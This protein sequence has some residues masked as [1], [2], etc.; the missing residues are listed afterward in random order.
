MAPSHHAPLRRLSE[1]AETSCMCA[2]PDRLLHSIKN[3]S[4]LSEDLIVVSVGPTGNLETRESGKPLM[5]TQVNEHKLEPDWLRPDF[6]S[7]PLCSICSE[8]QSILQSDQES[9]LQT[10]DSIR[11]SAETCP[12]CAIISNAVPQWQTFVPDNTR[13]VSIAPTKHHRVEEILID[14]FNIEPG[15]FLTGVRLKFPSM[16]YGTRPSIRQGN[17]ALCT[18]HGSSL[19]FLSSTRLTF[20]LDSQ[21]GRSGDV[22]GRVVL[23]PG[24]LSNAKVWLQNC[25][26][27]HKECWPP[28]A[29]F[30]ESYKPRLPT[31]V[32]DV[33]SSKG[34]IVLFVTEGQT[35]DYLSLSHR[36]G[37]SKIPITTTDNLAAHLVSIPWESLTRTFQDAVSVTRELGYRYL[38]IDSLCIV[39]DDAE[40]WAREASR[41]ADIYRH[42]T[43]T[44]SATVSKSGDEGLFTPRKYVNLVPLRDPLELGTRQPWAFL[45]DGRPADFLQDVAKGSLSTRAWCLQERLLSRRILHFGSDQLHWECICVKWSES[46]VENPSDWNDQ[47][48]GGQRLPLSSAA[49]FDETLNPPIYFH[50]ETCS[51]QIYGRPVYGKWYRLVSAYTARLMTVADDKLPALSG[52]T[53]T[54]AEYSGDRYLAG[55]WLK[56][57]APG[58]LWQDLRVGGPF[59]P[60]SHSYRLSKSRS[61]SWSWASCDESVSYP[62]CNIGRVSLDILGGDVELAT[63]DPYG[64]VTSGYLDVKGM[65]RPL[66][67]LRGFQPDD[68]A[69]QSQNLPMFPYMALHA[70]FDDCEEAQLEGVSCL[71]VAEIGCGSRACKQ[72]GTC[73]VLHGYGLLLRMVEDDIYR[74]V[75]LAVV[76]QLDFMGGK[77]S[78]IRLV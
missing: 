19:N 9:E 59:Q 71:Y 33:G 15:R 50:P 62:L 57:A 20:V 41:M 44:L 70:E 75:G 31:R 73:R 42:A 6:C 48:G 67:M 45:S 40:D 12:C 51:N 39:Q 43:L 68:I 16:E 7:S 60:I 2:F 32:I 24:N 28:A 72:Q 36:W 47:S 26:M 3:T 53:R 8:L 66:A 76:S 23:D 54:F 69:N 22:I 35:G 11:A 63:S 64:K 78:K 4:Q 74:R 55:H 61:P 65:L 14:V 5:V 18:R 21:T 27:V 1:G 38:W 49:A 29:N 46:S 77:L 52:I 25:L 56:D 13:P 17:L 10:F 34:D 58:L 30:S 37:T